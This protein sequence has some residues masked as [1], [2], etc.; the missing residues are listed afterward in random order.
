MVNNVPARLLNLESDDFHRFMRNELDSPSDDLVLPVDLPQWTEL[1]ISDWIEIWVGV[2]IVVPL[3]GQVEEWRIVFLQLHSGVIK[4][5]PQAH[6]SLCELL[7][8]CELKFRLLVEA[9]AALRV[10][11][12]RESLVALRTFVEKLADESGANREIAAA[13]EAYAFEMG[14]ILSLREHAARERE[15]DAETAR[16]VEDTGGDAD[17]ARETVV[18]RREEQRSERMSRW[19]QACVSPC[20]DTKSAC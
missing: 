2:I 11:T 12:D 16:E 17:V 1:P 3:T 15:L 14:T 4:Y 19:V 13:K 5:D 9:A 7:T 20:Q 18:K 6:P 8:A 10:G